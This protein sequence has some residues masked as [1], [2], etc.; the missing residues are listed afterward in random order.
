MKI[1]QSALTKSLQVFAYSSLIIFT[2]VCLFPLLL[3]ISASFSDSISILKYGYSL[4]PKDFTLQ[5]YK[6]VF[7]DPMELFQAYGVTT[8][9]MI[10]GTTVGLFL[11]S[12]TGYVLQR[13]DLK[14]RNQVAFYIYFTTIF[15]GGLIPWYILLTKYLHFTDSYLA[16]IIP[17]L[18]SPFLIIL[19]KSFIKSSVPE[20]L[21]ESAK[22]DGGNDW[23]VYYQIVLPIS[24]P[25]L[26]TVGLF[27]ALSH[28]NDWYLSSLFI[29]NPH[30]YEL[31]FYL[32]KMVAEMQVAASS[33]QISSAGVQNVPTSTSRMAMAVVV[34]GPIIFLYPFVQKYFV[35][36][37]TIGAV[38]G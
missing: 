14:Y 26:A 6:T 9:C 32:Y 29:N 37:L 8:S 24:L 22:I 38:K 4:I 17:G 33:A 35:K 7:A 27:L 28:W 36:G 34:T 19:M 13:R 18:I 11:I 20:E 2:A 30:K 15:G 16:L 25:G 31:Q 23:K 3:I 5:G 12:M 1:N 21:F 10:I